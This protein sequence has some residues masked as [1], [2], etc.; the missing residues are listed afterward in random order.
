MISAA[1]G[2]VMARRIL[3]SGFDWGRDLD[4]GNLQP[5]R[6]GLFVRDEEACRVDFRRIERWQVRQHAAA[7][8]WDKLLEFQPMLLPLALFRRKT[9]LILW[10]V[11]IRPGPN[12]EFVAASIS[13]HPKDESA[14]AGEVL[15]HGRGADGGEPA[16]VLQSNRAAKNGGPVGQHLK[17]TGGNTAHHIVVHHFPGARLGRVLE[18]EEGFDGC[19][20]SLH[21]GGHG[22]QRD[23]GYPLREVGQSHLCLESSRVQSPQRAVQDSGE[24]HPRQVGREQPGSGALHVPKLG[25]RPRNRQ[26]QQDDFRER[27]TH[28]V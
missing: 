19:R 14:E 12:A 17:L 27:H 11:E 9:A 23:H 5:E 22:Y 24:T 21:E 1:V 20:V 3:F 15:A 26:P 4:P 16:V 6:P 28:P 18:V 13:A 8:G 2:L 7:E 10:G 25:K